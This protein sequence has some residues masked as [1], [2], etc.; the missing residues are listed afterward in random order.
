M[1]ERRIAELFNVPGRFMR[2][3][4]L[5]RD[6]TDPHALDGYILTESVQQALERVVAGLRPTSG[7]RAWR[8]TGDY[9]TGKSS[10]GVLLAHLLGGQRDRLPPAIR[11][12]VDFRAL[13]IRVPSMLPLLVTGVPEGLAGA[14]ARSI[15]AAIQGLRSRGRI[16]AALAGVAARLNP[17]PTSDADVVQ[18]LGELCAYV[19][20]TGVASG[21]LVVI[22]ELGK[23]LEFAALHPDSADVYLL[24]CLAEAADRSG[25]HPVLLVGLLHQGFHAYAEQLP[26]AAQQEWEKV[27][28]RFEEVLFDQPL[29]HTSQLVAGAL[30]VEETQLP[31]AVSQ[32]A[33]RAMR[34]TL[35][36]GWYGA[37]ADEGSLVT[38][39]PFL[40]PL[41]PTVLPVL[42]RFLRRFGQHERSLFSFLLSSEPFAL[43][44]FA[45]RPLPVGEWYRL[46]HLYDYVRATYGHRLGG[47][48]YR[49]QWLRISG[50]IDGARGENDLAL[51]VLKAVGLLNLLDA[52]DLIAASEAVAVAVGGP[53]VAQAGRVVDSLADLRE[54]GLLFDRGAAGGLCLWPHTSVS[55]ERAFADAGRVLGPAN[56]ASELLAPHLDTRPL[57]AR[58]HY[59][60]TGTLRHFEVRFVA[61]AALDPDIAVNPSA[62]G[63]VLVPLCDSASDHQT[64]LAFAQST[65]LRTCPT[66]FIAVPKPL[67]H[68]A[69][70]V[71]DARRWQ[72]VVENTP[73]LNHDAY[74]AAEAA[75]QLDAARRALRMRLEAFVSLHSLSAA[76]TLRWFH[77]G[78]ETPI[79]NGRQLL[80]HISATCG[81][82]YA[83][84]P[85]VANELVNRRSLSSAA[86]KARMLLIQ[87]ILESASEPF[88]GIDPDRAPPEKSIYLSLLRQGGLHREVNGTFAITE[89]EADSDACNI[90]PALSC[91]HDLLV[92]RIDARVR[93]DEIFA[94]LRARPFGVRDGIIPILLA[95]YFKIHEHELASYEGGAFI[96]GVGAEEFLRMVKAPGTFELQ[97]CQVAG[98]RVELFEQLKSLLNVSVPRERKPQLLD[99]VTPLCEFAAR[100]PEYTRRTQEVSSLARAVRAILLDA[101]EPASL[102]FHQL[103]V[104]CGGT[105]FAPGENVDPERISAFVSSLRLALAELRDAF[106]ALHQ[107]NETAL[108]TA[109]GVTSEPRLVRRAIA[110]RARKILV[111]VREPR[112]KGFCLRLTDDNLSQELW[113]EA[114][115]SF[116]LAKPPSRWSD[117]DARNYGDGVAML[118]E[119]FQR[120]ESMAFASANGHEQSAM[121][122]VVTRDDGVEVDRVV[123]FAEHDEEAIAQ[124]E[125]RIAAVLASASHINLAAAS[126]VFWKALSQE[127]S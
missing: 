60:E 4:H 86:A 104:A 120:V 61:V 108:A 81:A 97:L 23:F 98:V 62:D 7:R 82:V 126:R 68:L 125:A 85:K 124:V 93:V 3:V 58:R 91:I 113:I 33:T 51:Q 89:P 74:A 118:A 76:S 36:L 56:C 90:R 79:R 115:A 35:P 26:T 21:V 2:S 112:I 106:T 53:N 102:L 92:M 117:A 25:E 28:G 121:R 38:R 95:V 10:F 83:A 22:D 77:R 116:V 59:I 12:A 66:V 80:E 31:R 71:Q 63:L 119:T 110:A 50:L 19:I 107:R 109:L 5:E 72:W 15:R 14:L 64:A 73:E 122:I 34:D 70:A 41:H 94:A 13:G 52:D 6:F 8:I 101:R 96:V 9:G 49:S 37:A 114:V 65:A 43:Q 42:V 1:S 111:A 40:Y 75:R 44:D 103:P 123:H 20:N 27:A 48:S 105:P 100:L 24:Q 29:A 88:L 11:R 16:P 84:S 46:H 78:E 57:V 47:Q 39:A 45:A 17:V 18:A 32:A 54:R 69:G 87:R 127:T 99:I 67:S 30:N 55:L